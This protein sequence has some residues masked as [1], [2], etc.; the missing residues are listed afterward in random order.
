M[1]LG[2]RKTWIETGV[3]PGF[4]F[5]NPLSCPVHSKVVICMVIT[6]HGDTFSSVTQLCPTLS[7]L[8]DCSTLGFPVHCQFPELTQIHVHPVGDETH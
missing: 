4:K 6:E 2:K 3:G 7:N 8:M 5:K 1:V